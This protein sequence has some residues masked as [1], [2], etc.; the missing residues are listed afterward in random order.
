M[1][2]RINFLYG[3]PIPQILKELAMFSEKA[4]HFVQLFLR[5]GLLFSVFPSLKKTP[6]QRM[7][8]AFFLSG[9]CYLSKCDKYAN[10]KHNCGQSIVLRLHR[11]LLRIRTS[12]TLPNTYHVFPI[13]LKILK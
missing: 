4:L 7:I 6:R 10:Y 1:S 3:L 11:T 2:K 8:P 12:G 5:S 9:K 13:N